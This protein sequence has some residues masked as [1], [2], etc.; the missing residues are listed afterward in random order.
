[1]SADT[2]VNINVVEIIE[3]LIDR[4]VVNRV[5][6]VRKLGVSQSAIGAWLRREAVPRGSTLARALVVT[7]S[8]LRKHPDLGREIA[9]GHGALSLREL[10]ANINKKGQVKHE[11]EGQLQTAGLSGR[12][13]FDW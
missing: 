7:R 13:A 1:M 5:G 4:K 10:Y 9:E 6:M 3:F 2:C 8:L 12:P 11:S